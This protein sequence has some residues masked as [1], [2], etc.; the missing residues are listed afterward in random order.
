[1]DRVLIVN[2]VLSESPIFLGD[3]PNKLRGSTNDE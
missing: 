1:M 3:E 2:H